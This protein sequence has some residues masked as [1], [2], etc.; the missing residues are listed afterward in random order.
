MQELSWLEKKHIKM[1]PVITIL[2]LIM[3][4][5]TSCNHEKKDLKLESKNVS[6]QKINVENYNM[7]LDYRGIVQPDET[8]NYAFLLSGK[9]EKIYVN[10]G[11]KI[12][13]GEILAKLDTE[14]LNISRDTAAQNVNSLENSVRLAKSNL[15]ALEVLSKNGAIASKEYEAKQTE[16]LNLLNSLEISKNNLNAANEGIKNAVIYSDMDGYVMESPYKEGEVVSAGYPVIIGKGEVLK[17]TVGIATKDLKKINASS[18]VL[19][20]KTIQGKIKN[21]SAFPDKNM[22][23]PID[24]TF[25][26]KE[27]VAGDT[28]DVQIVTGEETGYFIPLESIFNLDG[29]D[30]VYVV[31]QDNKKQHKV[32]KQQVELHEIK[33]DTI[34]VEGL[35][36]TMNVVIEGA[37]TLKENDIVTI[38][39]TQEGTEK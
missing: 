19:I 28:V 7:T 22:L 27:I 34:R 32:N 4:F 2:L 23:Y 16:Y 36:P 18:K 9:V 30:Y 10:K 5:F 17:V 3:I 37:K 24:I 14:S 38:A 13:P 26:S 25:D 11:Q 12:T 1:I 39:K 20:N 35:K 31:S 15:N 29:I 21:I 33:D 8:K 6:I